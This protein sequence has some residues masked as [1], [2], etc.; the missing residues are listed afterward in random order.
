MG[1]RL[2]YQQRLEL[3]LCKRKEDDDHNGRNLRHCLNLKH[4]QTIG[5]L[6]MKH[7]LYVLFSYLVSKVF[8]S[9]VL[10]NS[11]K[12]DSRKSSFGKRSCG[13]R[14]RDRDFS[15]MSVIN[16]IMIDSIFLNEELRNSSKN[17]GQVIVVDSGCPRSLLGDEELKRL[18]EL[19]EVT[20]HDV[21]D[22]FF[23][24]GP[25]R[26]YKSNKKVT[27][28]IRIGV[29][30]I[31]CELFVVKAEIPILLGNDVMVP[32]GGKIDM[33]EDK[34]V[35]KK[36]DM[37]IPLVQT[38]GGH[39]VI[40]VR[41]ISGVDA[42]NVKGDEADAVMMMVLEKTDNEFIKKL[43]DEVGHS[44]FVA[45][46]MTD[47]EEKQVEKV[48]RYFGHRSSRRI[49]ELF[50]KANKLRGKKQAV[51]EVIE[52]CKTCS[53]FKKSPPRPKVG[54]P[55]AND[56]NEI[57]GL[58]L[59]VVSSSKCEYILWMVDMF[60]KMIKGKYIKNNIQRQSLMES[61]V[62]G[63]WAMEW[64]LATPAEDSGVIMVESS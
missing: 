35:L 54:L 12:M 56:F 32:L 2:S 17:L 28:T 3:P 36:V 42:N 51:L 40:P 16:L 48:H 6:F 44:T 61:S 30:E 49:W 45:L 31:D 22:E 63:S 37:E 27:I 59:K 14:S 53:E 57:V 64:A 52:N 62:P 15:G 8:S 60:S 50:A 46:G 29:Q 26:V 13:S 5:K 34:L 21:K 23:R 1:A 7:L 41:S 39:F 4:K 55:V 58:D 11:G 20:E 9:Y 18:K 43:H 33:E 47:D 38:K 19:I 25:S 24:F 10:N